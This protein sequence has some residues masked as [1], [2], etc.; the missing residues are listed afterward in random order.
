MNR[1]GQPGEFAVI[2]EWIGKTN[3]CQCRFKG[4]CS[5]EPITQILKMMKGHGH[6]SFNDSLTIESGF[7]CLTLFFIVAQKACQVF[8]L[9]LA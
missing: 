1:A 6:L 9:T 7:D 2:K 8:D 5:T 4:L 3:F